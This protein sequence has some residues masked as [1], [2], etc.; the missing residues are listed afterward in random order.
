MFGDDLMGEG[1]DFASG[2][3]FDNAKTEGAIGIGEKILL[4]IGFIK[5]AIKFGKEDDRKFKAFTFMDAQNSHGL[6]ALRRR[7]WR[8][9]IPDL[10]AGAFR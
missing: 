1:G 3:R 10:P 8:N 6:L 5:L 2:F 9:Q 4:C 7:L